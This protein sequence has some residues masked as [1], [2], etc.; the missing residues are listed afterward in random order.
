M[1]FNRF[2]RRRGLRRVALLGV[3]LLSCGDTSDNRGDQAV[4]PMCFTDPKTHLEIINSCSDPP[5]LDKP[6]RLAKFSPGA[7]LQPLP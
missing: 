5:G 3:I 1:R 2:L 6:A 4:A 7:Q